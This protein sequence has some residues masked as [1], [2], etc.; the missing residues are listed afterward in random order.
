MV[1][2]Y[3]RLHHQQNE[4]LSNE[5]IK[6]NNGY[7]NHQV[8][9]PILKK[10]ASKTDFP[11]PS[12]THFVSIRYHI[13]ILMYHCIIS[14]DLVFSSFNPSSLHPLQGRER[15]QGREQGSGLRRFEL[16]RRTGRGHQHLFIACQRLGRR[17]AWFL[18]GI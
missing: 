1:L 7:G 4:L 17:E 8:Q 13:S 11:V 10:H 9:V 3:G 6:K 14:L 5:M 12:S 16:V 15:P 18:E 2:P